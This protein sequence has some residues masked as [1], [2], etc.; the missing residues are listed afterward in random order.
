MMVPPHLILLQRI[1]TAFI[2]RSE[3]RVS[4]NNGADAPTAFRALK[5]GP[6]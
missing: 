5:H 4:S 1:F 6:H 2:A 3:R